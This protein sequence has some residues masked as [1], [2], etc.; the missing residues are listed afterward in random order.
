M[1][2]TFARRTTAFPTLPTPITPRVHSLNDLPGILSHSPD[3]IAASIQGKRRAKAR[4]YPITLSDTG[5]V[6]AFGVF[7]TITPTEV[8]YD[9]SIESIPVPHLEMTFKR[10]RQTSITFFVK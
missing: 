4:I 5:K 7:P 10:G 6:K 3:F 8:A 1:P 2:K 9:L